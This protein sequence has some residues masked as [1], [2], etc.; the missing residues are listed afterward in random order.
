METGT[1]KI[2]RARFFNDKMSSKGFSIFIDGKEEGKVPYNEPKSFP[3]A[4]GKHEVYAKLNWGKSRIMTL[5]IK[6][7]ETKELELGMSN[8]PTKKRFIVA[9]I[10]AVIW[11]GLLIMKRVYH[12]EMYKDIAMYSCAVF[13]VSNLIIDKKKNA[14]YSITF[15][16]NDYLYLKEKMD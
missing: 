14:I 15:G 9:I 2:T 7:N 12:D 10:F 13:V 8:P 3:L 5:D 1:L 16:R 6:A 4:E 11:F